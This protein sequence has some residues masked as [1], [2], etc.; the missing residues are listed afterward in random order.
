[1]KYA[2]KIYTCKYCGKQFKSRKACSTR[3]PQYCSK[4][5]FSEDIKG[6]HG[7]GVHKGNVPWNKGLH[8]WADKPHPRGTLG[9]PSLLKGVKLSLEMR[10]KLSDSHRGLK[11]PNN[12]GENSHFWK[13]G[14]T[15]E[16]E[17]QR[18][19]AE[20]NNW[21]LA[22]FERDHYTCQDCH[23]VGGYLHAHHIKKF[24]EYPELRFDVENGIT[25]CMECHAKRHGLIFSTKALNSCP[26]CGKSIKVGA[27]Y[28]RSCR[29]KHTQERRNRCIDYG[30]II[31]KNSKRCRSCAAKI[32]I[33]KTQNFHRWRG[34]EWKDQKSNI[35]QS[36][37]L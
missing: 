11:Y 10:K 32:N 6:K 14:I 28:C 3:T 22:V 23:K 33:I 37:S 16:N 27:K 34:M 29:K 2:D 7:G 24:S 19:S 20:Y 1:M 4:E 25:L 26:D 21:R 17:K 5:C 30:A 8:M 31:T 36:M 35:C 12:A 18:K 15:P 9:K 13:G